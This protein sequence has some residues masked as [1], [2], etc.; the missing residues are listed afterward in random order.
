M[1]VRNNKDEIVAIDKMWEV[2]VNGRACYRFPEDLDITLGPGDT[3]TLWLTP[4]GGG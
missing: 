3:I 2:R 1:V 4:L